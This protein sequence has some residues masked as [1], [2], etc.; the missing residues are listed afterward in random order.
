MKENR[1]LREAELQRRKRLWCGQS[2]LG[3]N[4][5]QLVCYSKLQFVLLGLGDSL[6]RQILFPP[7]NPSSFKIF[8]INMTKSKFCFRCLKYHRHLPVRVTSK[9]VLCFR[10]LRLQNNLCPVNPSTSQGCPWCRLQFGVDA[11]EAEG[12][13]DC[14]LHPS[15]SPCAKGHEAEK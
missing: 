2:R 3:R 15:A 6:L 1:V 4:L 12:D 11:G 5:E 7:R 9:K 14:L 8:L 13:A 10:A